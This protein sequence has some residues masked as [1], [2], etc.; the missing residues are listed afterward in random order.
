MIQKIYGVDNLIDWAVSIK[1]GKATMRV[2]FTGGAT[3][4]R[5]IVPATF[6]TADPVKQAI[7]EKSNY[8]KTGQIRV[9][10]VIEVPDNAAAIARKERKAAR[11]AAKASA[12]AEKPVHDEGENAGEGTE[13]ENAVD[14]AE[15]V[16]VKKTQVK[17]SSVEDAKDYLVDKFG[18]A[19]SKLRTR[20]AC[21]AAGEENGIEFIWE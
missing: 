14:G 19:S 18:I 10:Q 11:I 2:H 6:A 16:A 3:T 1:A 20:A 9:V 12:S 4:A 8:F 7:I 5:G 13:D 17:V 21:I 15:G